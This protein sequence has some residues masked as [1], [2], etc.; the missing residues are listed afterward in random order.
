MDRDGGLRGNN[1]VL[2][3]ERLEQVAQFRYLGVD[4]DVGVH[5][6]IDESWGGT[7]SKGS[8]GF[9]GSLE[10]RFRA[11]E[12]K[13]GMFGRI[14]VPTV[15]NGCE[16]W[17]LNAM[18]GKRIHVLKMKCLRTVMEVRWFDRLRK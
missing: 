3:N 14:V 15:L 17:A 10:K 16:A 2:N 4:I 11:V 12:P 13:I 6:G 1:I 18:S 8:R 5:G 7:G 9:E